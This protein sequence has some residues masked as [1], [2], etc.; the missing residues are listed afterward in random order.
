[1]TPYTSFLAD[2][3][4]NLS[5]GVE[6]RRHMGRMAESLSQDVSGAA[7]QRAWV[8]HIARTR[9]PYGVTT[10]EL[11]EMASASCGHAVTPNRISGRVSE[12]LK[13]RELV[14]TSRRRATSTGS[15]AAVHVLP[16]FYG[17]ATAKSKD[18]IVEVERKDGAE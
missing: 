10:D 18:F 7:G 4:V 12:L 2:E 15:S 5:S 13:T 8:L 3:T 1:M 9:G 14:R 6:V 17:Q 11:C 16:Q